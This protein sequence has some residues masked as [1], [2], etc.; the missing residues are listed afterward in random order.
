M[1]QDLGPPASARVWEASGHGKHAR[2]SCQVDQH[3]PPCLQVRMSQMSTLLS[4]SCRLMTYL[5]A[6]ASLASIM[7]GSS[8]ICILMSQHRALCLFATFLGG[9][10]G[11][12]SGMGQCKMHP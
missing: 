9:F 7:Q 5:E 11:F 1:V 3:G 2:N 4:T 12:D 6:S 8:V 10:E